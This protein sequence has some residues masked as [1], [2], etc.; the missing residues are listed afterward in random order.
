[1]L[2]MT[3]TAVAI[4]DVEREIAGDMAKRSLYVIPLL[5]LIGGIFWGTDGMLSVL[6]ASAL[7]VLNF[8]LSARVLSWAAR[9]SP[10]AFMFATL[11][12]YVLR[13]GIIT[14]AILAVIHMSWVAIVPMVLTLALLHLG[15]LAAETR[16][17]SGSLAYPG[18]RPKRED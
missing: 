11:F 3:D 13:L 7:V 5:V 4:P 15:L 8:L 6:Y 10:G 17:V 1:M 18:L 16:Y 12:G 2:S 14:V 9:I